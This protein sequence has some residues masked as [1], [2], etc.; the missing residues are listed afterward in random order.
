MGSSR[1]EVKGDDG[2]HED[3]RKFYH[4]S[5]SIQERLNYKRSGISS[6]EL[7]SA[8]FGRSR[9]LLLEIDFDLLPGLV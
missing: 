1:K 5:G 7:K 6:A 4:K 3:H 9:S 8:P 2:R